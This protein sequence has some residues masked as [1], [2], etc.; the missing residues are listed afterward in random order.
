[1]QRDVSSTPGPRRAVARTSIR[2]PSSVDSKEATLSM[3][4]QQL[5]D[6]VCVAAEDVLAL[7]EL[8][9]DGQEDLWEEEG[10]LSTPVVDAIAHTLNPHCERTVPQLWID[11]P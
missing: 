9:Y 3:T 5:A 10:V 7:V 6:D 8:Y 11:R 1:M 2:L 4:A